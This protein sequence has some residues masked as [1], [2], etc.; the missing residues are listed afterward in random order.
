MD[1]LIGF[2]AIMVIV[3]AAFAVGGWLIERKKPNPWT[4]YN[5]RWPKPRGF[6]GW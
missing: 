5:S 1:N 4:S 3:W 6:R 2:L